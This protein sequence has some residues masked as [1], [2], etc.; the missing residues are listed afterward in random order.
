[1]LEDFVDDLKKTLNQRLDN[2]R[3]ILEG[4]G[5]PAKPRGMIEAL[6]T[7]LSDIDDLAERYRAPEEV[8]EQLELADEPAERPRR[9][10]GRAA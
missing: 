8:P 10:Y 9:S 6:K 1:M 7:A 2:A 5:E 3:D 4:S